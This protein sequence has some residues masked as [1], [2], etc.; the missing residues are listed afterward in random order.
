M[1]GRTV[2]PDATAGL[3]DKSSTILPEVMIFSEGFNEGDRAASG[4]LSVPE[5]EE[6]GHSAVGLPGYVMSGAKKDFDNLEGSRVSDLGLKIRQWLLEVFPLRGQP[7]GKRAKFDLFPLPTSCESLSVFFPDLSPP[8]CSWLSCVRMGLN[9]LWGTEVHYS[10]P[11]NQVAGDCLARLK[12]DV[13]RM[14]SLREELAS[15][16]WEQ[17]FKTRAIDYKG[18]EV[19]TAR[20]FCW[21][22]ISPAL[23]PEVGTVPLEEVCSLGALHYVTNIDLYIKPR[24][25]WVLR[26]P[27]RVM[28]GQAA[29]G[30]VCEGLLN[31][32]ICTLLPVEDVFHVDDAPL[33]NG[34]F[35]VTK[36]EWAGEHEI[37][38]LI[39]NL[40][41]FS[42]IA[43]PISGDVETL[44]MWSIMN[45]FFLEANDTLIVSSEDVRCFFYTMRVPTNWYKYLAFNRTVPDSCLPQDLKGRE[46]YLAS[47]VLPM[48]FAN[49]VSLAQHVHRNLALWSGENSDQDAD[50]VMAPEAEIRKDRPVTVGNPSWRIYLDN[51][52]LLDKVKSVDACALEGSLA[53]AVLALRQQYE[54]LG[55]TSQSQEVCAKT[56]PSRGPRGAD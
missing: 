6:H 25:R 45:P 35:G 51:Y 48:G 41:P 33:L 53:P 19:K 26:K 50:A 32:G 54:V 29:W 8:L 20:D 42:G 34:L 4:G 39:M 14:D 44:P 17:F 13:E 37:Y 56:C 46:V 16:D 12:A 11:V 24:D 3:G 27:P 55:H 21:E 9:S 36:D 30:K 5:C 7:T 40:T 23:P 28:V 18:D 2:L 43:E 52:D 49:S 15:F 47:R 22:N 31:S 38:R 10:G 1:P